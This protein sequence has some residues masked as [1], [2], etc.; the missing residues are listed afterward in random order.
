MW[1]QCDVKNNR[2]KKQSY[3]SIYAD[4]RGAETQPEQ[5]NHEE[6][7][8]RRKHGAFETKKRQDKKNQRKL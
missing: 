7:E 2:T 1:M 8:Y 6:S 5:K 4:V 3:T